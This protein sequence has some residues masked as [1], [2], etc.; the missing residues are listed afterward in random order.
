MYDRVQ[1][2]VLYDWVQYFLFQKSILYDRVQYIVL[3]DWVQYTLFK[4][5]TVR[6]V[7]YS[8]FQKSILYD[9]VQYSVLYDR[10]QYSLFQKSILYDRMQYI[11][12]YDRVQYTLFKIHTIRPSAVYHFIIHIVRPSAMYLSCHTLYDRVKCI[13]CIC[14]MYSVFKNCMYTTLP[15][16]VK[17]IATK[18]GNCW[19]PILG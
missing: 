13:L 4:I 7:Q 2:S 15:Q 18:G 8:L 3:Y 17:Q 19:H 10:V 6:R 16:F 11:V 12:L 5:Y 14:I 9:R 1:Y